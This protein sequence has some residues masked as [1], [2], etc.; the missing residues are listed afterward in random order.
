MHSG[1]LRSF[2]SHPLTD[3]V[4]KCSPDRL[5]GY[6]L[7]DCYKPRMHNCYAAFLPETT[8]FEFG[9]NVRR[10]PFPLLD[11]QRH[12]P[13]LWEAFLGAL[14]RRLHVDPYPPEV[15]D[16]LV[17]KY[18]GFKLN[19]EAKRRAARYGVAWDIH[20]DLTPTGA[21]AAIASGPPEAASHVETTL[22]QAVQE[23]TIAAQIRALAA[24]GKHAPTMEELL[25]NAIARLALGV[26]Y[27]NE[28]IYGAAAGAKGLDPED[29]AP[30][31]HSLGIVL[32][33]GRR[34]SSRRYLLL[35]NLFCQMYMQGF[36]GTSSVPVPVLLKQLAAEANLESAYKPPNLVGTLAHEVPMAFTQ[37]FAPL[38]DV[39]F[40]SELPVSSSS[41]F[42]GDNIS[43]KP[44][45]SSHHDTLQVN[46][47][48]AHLL[49]VRA[50]GD[51]STSTALPD[52]FG[53]PGFIRTALAA[54]L[55]TAFVRDM[56]LE[57]PS[58]WSGGAAWLKAPD[59]VVFDLFRTWRVDSGD[60]ECAAEEIL[61]AWERRCCTMLQSATMS[62][63]PDT[64]C[65]DSCPP[66]PQLMHSNL[67]SYDDVVRAAHLP[68]RIRPRFICF[69]TLAD[70]FLPFAWEEKKSHGAK[71]PK[72]KAV[73]L[74]SI[75]MKVMQARWSDEY[76]LGSVDTG[77]ACKR[78]SSWMPCAGKLGDNTASDEAHE[79]KL[80]LD[81]RLSANDRQIVLHRMRDMSRACVDSPNGRLAASMALEKAYDCAVTRR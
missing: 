40:D 62:A 6:L 68:K 64:P 21:L 24:S 70:G 27:L 23:V 45:N 26:A 9:L 55:P 71:I 66:Q 2:L 20:W 13:E 75:V 16:T 81:W 50:N 32:F 17:S 49:M 7:N 65:L 28:G 5:D 80:Q 48:L 78:M 72:S 44:P 33:A 56:A 60:Y 22:T 10:T 41:G 36:A 12:D 42:I 73:R 34:S 1:N 39:S 11:I 3:K 67:E 4:L 54:G 77:G 51:L 8:T 25:G 18:R 59:A 47:L 14:K 37:L 69:G 19:K 79:E 29:D 35:Q 31:T 52:T 43:S 15:L 63:G 38:D 58:Q 76:A 61:S 30:T 46:A 74:G 57:Y 53:T